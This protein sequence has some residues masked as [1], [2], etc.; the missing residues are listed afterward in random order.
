MG[1]DAKRFRSLSNESGRLEAFHLDIFISDLIVS[2]PKLVCLALP[3]ALEGFPFSHELR[4]IESKVVAVP[5][6]QGMVTL[7]LLSI[8]DESQKDPLLV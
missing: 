8:H 4:S 5:F 1:S 6:D 7:S 2:T 3:A